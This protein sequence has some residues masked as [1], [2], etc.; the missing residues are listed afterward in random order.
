MWECTFQL[1]LKCLEK[2]TGLS[3]PQ[4][5]ALRISLLNSAHKLSFLRLFSI[6][7]SRG[8]IMLLHPSD[9]VFFWV[10]IFVV[11]V[12]D[13]T[14]QIIDIHLVAEEATDSTESLAELV[15]I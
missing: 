5:G 2:K 8:F 3:Q 14:H 11:G 6:N 1:V 12:V 13:S 15:A 9:E 10:E 4:Q 7:T